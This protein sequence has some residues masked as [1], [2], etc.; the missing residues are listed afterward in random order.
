M[1]TDVFVQR[2]LNTT[3]F[4]VVHKDKDS[5]HNEQ[6]VLW[7]FL[8]LLADLLYHCIQP[9]EIMVLC[10]KYEGY[11]FPP[12]W[13]SS[14]LLPR[15]AINSLFR[16][17]VFQSLSLGKNINILPCLSPL[18]STCRSTWGLVAWLVCYTSACHLRSWYTSW[19]WPYRSS[20][21][22]FRSTHTH[23]LTFNRHQTHTGAYTPLLRPLSSTG[24][25]N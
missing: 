2:D 21:L 18:L 22:S 16:V 9:S 7:K 23:S 19:A 20:A 12:Q 6:E 3:G 17:G 10:F 14:L 24:N 13:S 11:T 25:S 8:W 1:L 5:Q 15:V 4:S